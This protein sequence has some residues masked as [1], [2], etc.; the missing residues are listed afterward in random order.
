MQQPC[1]INIPCIP[2]ADG[3]PIAGYGSEIDDVPTALSPLPPQVCVGAAF[4]EVITITGPDTVNGVKTWALKGMLP[5]GL[6]FFAVSLNGTL[7]GVVTTPGVYNFTVSVQ[8]SLGG[9]VQQAYTVAVA[10]VTAALPGA[11][12]GQPYNAQIQTVGFANP[13]FVK[14]SGALPDGLTLNVNGTVTG[15]PVSDAV[16]SSFGFLI[17][18]GPTGFQC[19]ETSSIKV[20]QGA[21]CGSVPNLISTTA[22]GSGFTNVAQIA[23]RSAPQG[24]DNS[25]YLGFGDASGNGFGLFNIDT[26]ATTRL[27][28]PGVNVEG[29]GYD[30]SGDL[31]VL[32]CGDGNIRR[33]GINPLSVISTVAS[34]GATGG[35]I[36]TNPA[37][38]IMYVVEGG[39][40][41]TYNPVTNTVLNNILQAGNTFN[42]ASFDT[43][44]NLMYV[45]CSNG[46]DFPNPEATLLIYDVSGTGIP[47]QLQQII[48]SPFDEMGGNG[49]RCNTSIFCPENN[50]VYIIGVDAT[51][52]QGVLTR[53]NTLTA[54]FQNTTV[55]AFQGSEAPFPLVDPNS[56]LV[57]LQTSVFNS[58]DIYC[59]FTDLLIGGINANTLFSGVV[60][61]PD[62]AIWFVDNTASM[63]KYQ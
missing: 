14:I 58:V 16:T 9:F 31:F 4:H 32:S 51:S 18:D 38:G 37:S 54:M 34:G 20:T 60:V 25:R 50:L 26:L 46:N 1:P 6:T 35:P 24:A 40:I 49:S 55:L 12:T 48:V 13:F 28:I 62:K 8:G 21:T 10:A 41:T 42:T 33:V 57:Y 53:Y 59:S 11:T 30:V 36:F 63:S 7:N 27:A 2:C 5:P 19:L 15:A 23:F 56:N 45:D 29:V 3:N 44:H 22:I 52:F 17:T 47:N 39:R 61:N 43:I